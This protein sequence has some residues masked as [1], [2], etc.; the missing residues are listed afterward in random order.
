MSWLL[1][2]VEFL[3]LGLNSAILLV[4]LFQRPWQPGKILYWL[5]ASILTIGLIKMRG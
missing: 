1:K 5:G 2:H 3:A 4:M